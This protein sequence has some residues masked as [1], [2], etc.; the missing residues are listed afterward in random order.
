MKSMGMIPFPR[1]ALT[2]LHTNWLRKYIGVSCAAFDP[3]TL[4]SMRVT[5]SPSPFSYTRQVHFT[6]IAIVHAR[7]YVI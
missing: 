1:L 5:F 2:F 6:L 7:M 4:F 3:R